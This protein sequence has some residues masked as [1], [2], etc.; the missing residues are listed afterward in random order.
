GDEA[1]QLASELG[2]PSFLPGERG[3]T[4]LVLQPLLGSRTPA[5][6]MNFMAMNLL[7]HAWP[8]MLP[9]ADRPGME[10]ELTWN[11]STIPVPS[12][13]LSPPLQAFARALELLRSG[14]DASGALGRVSQIECQGPQKNLGTLALYASP[15]VARREL[16]TGDPAFAPPV[17]GP[18]HHCALL[19]APE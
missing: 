11:G 19:R 5:Q 2:L 15:I 3:T 10:F 4:L 17:S 1:D 12:P 16:D 6:A 8:K 7:W 13:G 18:A 9:R 14:R